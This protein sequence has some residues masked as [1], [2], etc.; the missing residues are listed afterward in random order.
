[1][2]T[3]DMI[4]TNQHGNSSIPYAKKRLTHKAGRCYLVQQGLYDKE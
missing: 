4:I 1:M 3:K 2:T